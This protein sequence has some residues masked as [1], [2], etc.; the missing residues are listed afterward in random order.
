[1]H[2]GNF[3]AHLFQG[4]ASYSAVNTARSALSAFLPLWDGVSVGSHPHVCRIV[5]GVFEQRPALPRYADT[6]DVNTV[7]NTLKLYS[8][9]EKLPLKELTLKTAML[10]SLVTRQRGYAIHTLQVT[11]FMFSHSKC[12]ISYSQKHKTTR[13]RFHTAP[14]E[15]LLY[16]DPD[17]C[18]VRTVK[19]YINKT[20]PLHSGP[21]LFISYDK[22]HS[23]VGRQTVAR[24]VKT[25]LE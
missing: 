17:L 12:T 15:L 5:K 3:L 9:L 21:E 2:V 23:P 8:P 19:E 22:P 6:W 25:M 20:Q 13:P 7:L 11:D 14:S 16:S 24:W 4:G 10:L 1:M 18:T